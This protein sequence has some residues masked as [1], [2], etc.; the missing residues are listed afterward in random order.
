MAAM[1]WFCQGGMAMAYAHIN[2]IQ[3]YYQ[4]KG[5]GLPILFIH[6]PLL[7]SEN[8]RYQQ[9]QLSNKF[10]IITFDI[11]GHGRSEP[12]QAALTYPLI[13]EDMKQ[14]LD[15]LKI[16]QCYV[17]G[18]ST[19]GAIALEAQLTYPDRFVGGILISAMSEFS[20]WYNRGRLNAAIAVTKLGA[21]KLIS[22]AIT[23]GNADQKQ[24]YQL[25]Y[26]A[27][28]RGAVK[29]MHE[30]YAYSKNYNCTDRLKDIHQPQLLIY[31]EKDRSFQQY[32]KLMERKLPDS[33]VHLIYGAKHQIPTK[34]ADELNATIRLWLAPAQPR[35]S[36]P[37]N[38]VD[39]AGYRKE[40][41]KNEPIHPH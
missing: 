31:G 2:G 30:Y 7:T 26:R 11:R 38:V 23:K 8:F 15:H 14:L 35:T 39:L 4:K 25:L 19:G 32:K 18:Y 27:A 9:I 17:C 20:D 40:R 3:L 10:C 36:M 37:E 12:S 29:N 21:K 22:K 24:T 41:S 33:T 1:V 5:A 16:E 13:V 34:N 6:P 28:I